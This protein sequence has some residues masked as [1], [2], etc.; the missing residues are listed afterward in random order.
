MNTRSKKKAHRTGPPRLS[1]V[2]LNLVFLGSGLGPFGPPRNDTV[3]PYN[4]SMLHTTINE[5]I[6]RLGWY[7]TIPFKSD[8]LLRI[9]AANG[10]AMAPQSGNP[11]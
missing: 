8:L 2:L 3:V 11:V 6:H 9:V 4:I 7:Q 1:V 10:A 5:Q